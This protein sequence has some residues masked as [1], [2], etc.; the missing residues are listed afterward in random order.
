MAHQWFLMALSVRPGRRLL[1]AAHRLPSST[2]LATIW[3]A[4]W[5]EHKRVWR[6]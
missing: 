6:A 2:W 1:M 4:G 5:V 3:Q